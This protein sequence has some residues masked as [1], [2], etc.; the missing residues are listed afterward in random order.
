MCG[1]S[2]CVC[3]FSIFFY[4]CV[5]ACLSMCVCVCMY[6]YVCK[7]I[8]NVVKYCSVP[9]I[10]CGCGGGAYELFNTLTVS[11]P[12]IIHSVS[13]YITVHFIW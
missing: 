5:C 4:V 11:N 3:F 9:Y 1:V 13:R 12:C 2:V 10:L 6:V 8:P 7:Y